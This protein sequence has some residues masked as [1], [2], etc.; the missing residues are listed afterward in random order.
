M[1]ANQVAAERQ[2][3]VS[4][5]R[6]RV[7]CPLDELT[8]DGLDAI[9]AAYIEWHIGFFGAIA[10]EKAKTIRSITITELRE[11]DRRQRRNLALR[12]VFRAAAT[13][14]A[15]RAQAFVRGGRLFARPRPLR[16]PQGRRTS[17]RRHV[18]RTASSRGDPSEPPPQ[19]DRLSATLLG[20]VF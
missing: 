15:V 3:E 6:S 8:E 17:R 11:F 14:R 16:R 7:P 5:L 20:R 10:P 18:A 12:P 13:A 2:H 4:M 19:R 9:K 1:D